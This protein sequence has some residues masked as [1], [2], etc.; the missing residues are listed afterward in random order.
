MGYL[1][2]NERKTFNQNFH[3][4]Q[5]KQII[6]MVAKSTG[7]DFLFLHFLLF[8]L[9]WTVL[10]I[11]FSQ[12]CLQQF[13]SH[14]AKAFE[15][16]I[17]DIAEMKPVV[18]H[19]HQMDFAEGL[20]LSLRAQEKENKN[21]KA[22]VIVRLMTLA[23][24][25]LHAA[26]KAVP[27]DTTTKYAL[28]DA[29]QTLA[30]A[31]WQRKDTLPSSEETESVP[32]VAKEQISPQPHESLSRGFELYRSLICDETHTRCSKLKLSYRGESSRWLSWF[33]LISTSLYFVFSC[34]SSLLGHIS[35]SGF[36][37]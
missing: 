33:P 11:I 1:D 36:S 17:S 8:L 29:Y 22:G 28:A 37:S 20:M 35:L 16:T 13:Q 5:L 6:T 23:I 15:F 24:D 26:L 31:E 25:K 2:S 30:F 12:E 14:R 3:D 10:G 19:M 18:K 27:D 4:F 34:P 9:T 32:R 7:L 21:E